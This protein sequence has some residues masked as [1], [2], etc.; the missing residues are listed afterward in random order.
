[1]DGRGGGSEQKHGEAEDG[2]LSRHGNN[3]LHSIYWGDSHQVRPL[4]SS[5]T[6]FFWRVLG[7]F[8]GDFGRVF[9]DFGRE[10]RLKWPK[11]D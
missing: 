11:R 3:F 6:V 7:G 9:A 8:V 5:K 1:M 2:H 10:T 4:G